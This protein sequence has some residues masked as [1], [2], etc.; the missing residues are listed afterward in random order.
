MNPTVFTPGVL[1]LTAEAEATG[2]L[3]LGSG[4]ETMTTGGFEAGVVVTLGTGA[5]GVSES[6]VEAEDALI[7]RSEQESML[8]KLIEAM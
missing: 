2:T 5:E 8:T 4:V 3:T 1:G 7:P 6:E